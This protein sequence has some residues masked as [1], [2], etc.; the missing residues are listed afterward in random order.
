MAPERCTA[1]PGGASLLLEYPEA[2][3]TPTD[4]AY[5]FVRCLSA[6]DDFGKKQRLVRLLAG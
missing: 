1:R 4:S 5:P 6:P 2:D 3:E